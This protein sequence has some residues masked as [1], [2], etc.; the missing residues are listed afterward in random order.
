M[1]GGRPGGRPAIYLFVTIRTV[2]VKS[3]ISAAKTA[4]DLAR[5]L[6]NGLAK[7]QIN[8]EEVP[9]RLM[10]LQQLILDLQS[11][12]HDMA[13]ENRQLRRQLDELR[14]QQ[15]LG[16]D[17]EMVDDGQFFVRKSERQAGRPILYCPVCWGVNQKLVPLLTRSDERVL[18]CVVHKALYYTKAYREESRSSSIAFGVGRPIFDPNKQF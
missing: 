9:A 15:Q 8:P 3:A 6:Q 4:F 16:D 7:Q 5:A 14:A 12:L 17:L 10:E 18:E 13:E 2:D 1:P 11:N